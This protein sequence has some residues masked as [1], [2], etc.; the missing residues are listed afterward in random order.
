MHAYPKTQRRSSEESKPRFEDPHK[1]LTSAEFAVISRRRTENK[2]N[3]W[4]PYVERIKR[5]CR[6][7]KEDWS[8]RPENKHPFPL[9]Y[10]RKQRIAELE[11][12]VARLKGMNHFQ[13]PPEATGTENA[14][15]NPPGQCP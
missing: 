14:G 12:E 10:D 13:P 5:Y 7:V 1:N 2:R 8:Y 6:P 15:E 11:A 3:S 4:K 9:G